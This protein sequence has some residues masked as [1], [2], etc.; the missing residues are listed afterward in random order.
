MF[1]GRE[2]MSTIG[3]LA[4]AVP[5]ELRAYKLAY[6]KFGGGVDGSVSWEDLFQPTIDLCE[7]G[8]VVSAS[9]AAAIQQTEPFILKDPAL[10]LIIQYLQKINLFFRFFRELFV[11]NNQTNALYVAGDIMKRPKYAETLRII[12]KQGVDAFYTGVLADKIVKEIQ[13]RGGIITKQDLANYQVDFQEALNIS[14]ND[15][16]TAFTTQAPSSGPILTFILNILRGNLFFEELEI[17]LLD[18]VKD[19][20]SIKMI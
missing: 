15:S 7:N 6:D 14:L 9:Q 8:F 17:L 20:K 18:F 10:R 16:L 13:D 2:N 1:I 4:I 3:G 5:G 11:K 12:A 19:I